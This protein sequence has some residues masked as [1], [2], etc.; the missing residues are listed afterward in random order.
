MN[1]SL[2]VE[3][4]EGLGN[5]LFMYSN[6]YALANNKKINLLID[7]TSGYFKKKNRLRGQKYLLDHFNVKQDIAQNTLKSDTNIK[8]FLDKF[9]LIFNRFNNQKKYLFENSIMIDGKKRITHLTD[10]SKTDFQKNILLKGNFEDENYFFSYRNELINLFLVKPQYIKDNTF[11]IDKLKNTNSVSIHVRQNRFSDQNIKKDNHLNLQKSKNFL[12]DNLNYIDRSIDFY[13]SK[14]ENPTF[15]IWSNDFI[16]LD[17]YF[18]K[19]KNNNFYFVKNNDEVN[20]F[21][22]FRFAKNF[23]V[24]PS[25]FHWWGAWLNNLPDKI[26]VRPNNINPSNNDNFWPKKWIKI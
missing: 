20:D 9:N 6:A 2:I 24:G 15:F 23:A 17:N 19:Y 14:I 26:C 12:D 3:I 21:N 11:L 5:Q 10:F 18:S 25:T 4:S 1:N 22:L 8:Y 16:D 13:N 7:D